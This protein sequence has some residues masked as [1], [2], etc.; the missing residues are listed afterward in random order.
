MWSRM[1][2]WMKKGGGRG[3]EEDKFCLGR[4]KRIIDIWRRMSVRMK[5]KGDYWK[6]RGR[7]EDKVC[8][9]RK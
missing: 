5:G 7:E 9:G 1:F 4:K 2:R 3:M 8:L 6:G